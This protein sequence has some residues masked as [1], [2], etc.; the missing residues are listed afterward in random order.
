MGL[1]ASRA[2]AA[3]FLGVNDTPKG[4]PFLSSVFLFPFLLGHTNPTEKPRAALPRASALPRVVS[5][6]EEESMDKD[7]EYGL[8]ALFIM[9][10]IIFLMIGAVI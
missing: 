9:A 2:N 5:E 7:T 1:A 3:P 10:P 4:A 8:L 6:R